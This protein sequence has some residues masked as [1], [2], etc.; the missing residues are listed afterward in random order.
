MSP[1]DAWPTCGDMP[2]FAEQ[3][4]KIPTKS[5]ELEP[6]VFNRAQQV[7][8]VDEQDHAVGSA[9]KFEAYPEV[10]PGR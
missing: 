2:A 5:G 9:D 6:L 10:G 1:S 7:A 4:L 8:L 3:C